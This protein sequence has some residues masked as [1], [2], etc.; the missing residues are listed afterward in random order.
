MDGASEW[1]LYTRIA[2]PLAAPSLAATA[3]FLLVMVWNDLL[4]PML[5][6]SSKSKLTLPPHLCS[7]AEN[8]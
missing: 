1:R 6:L 5:M 2:L 8:T 7:S 4:I 3:T